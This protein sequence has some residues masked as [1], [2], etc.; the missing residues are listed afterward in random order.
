[1]RENV[2][3]TEDINNLKSY[4]K[5]FGEVY[6]MMQNED[7]DSCSEGEEA[8]DMMEAPAM[9]SES[10]KKSKAK[11]SAPRQQSDGLATVLFKASKNKKY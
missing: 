4:K 1:M 2:T 5:D 8:M 7:Y 9:L 11:K 3:K 6:G 10:N